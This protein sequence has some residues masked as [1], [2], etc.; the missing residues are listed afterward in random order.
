MDHLLR[1]PE[2]G[3]LCRTPVSTSFFGLWRFTFY[4]VYSKTVSITFQLLVSL[5][6][7][8]NFSFIL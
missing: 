2:A 5:A 4:T 8:V 7:D 1:K 3:V 6:H